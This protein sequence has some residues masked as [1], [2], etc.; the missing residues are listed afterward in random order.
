MFIEKL[1]GDLIYL[2]W[3]LFLNEMASFRNE[4]DFQNGHVVLEHSL[5]DIR[6]HDSK[7]ENIVLR[8]H[9]QKCWSLNGITCYFPQ[10]SPIPV[11][12]HA[13]CRQIKIQWK[14]NTCWV[15][16]N[17]ILLLALPFHGHV[18]NLHRESKPWFLI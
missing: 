8:T 9:Y 6:L 2:F 14:K 5:I 16:E 15:S 10:F 3:E 11:N 1:N 17:Q 18:R 12:Q 13:K 7:F 4:F